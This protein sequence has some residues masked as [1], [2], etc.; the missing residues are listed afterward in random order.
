MVNRFAVAAA[1]TGTFS[2]PAAGLDFLKL[3]LGGVVPGWMVGR[4]AVWTRRR[5]AQFPINIPLSLLTSFAS[6]LPTEALGVSSVL[7]VVT[8][9]LV[10]GWY[11]PACIPSE[12]RLPSCARKRG[13]QPKAETG[14]FFPV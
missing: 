5:M 8:T 11:A 9:G 14:G 4:L 7:A 6:Y 13:P 10:V 2:L 12:V 1:A 3:V